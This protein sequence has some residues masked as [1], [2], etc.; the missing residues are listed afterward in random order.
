[1]QEILTQGITMKARSIENVLLQPLAAWNIRM[2][3]ILDQSVEDILESL[4]EDIVA[5]RLNPQI[6]IRTSW[7]DPRRPAEGNVF[8]NRGQMIGEDSIMLREPH[9][10]FV[11]NSARFTGKTIPDLIPLPFLPPLKVKR[12]EHDK[13]GYSHYVFNELEPIP[14]KQHLEEIRQDL[15]DPVYPKSIEEALR[16]HNS[17]G[18]TCA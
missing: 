9:A 11:A 4:A 3:A 6:S 13:Q 10:A 12:T 18:D 17:Q 5:L 15:L 7:R 8:L 14:L 1:M 16:R 2:T